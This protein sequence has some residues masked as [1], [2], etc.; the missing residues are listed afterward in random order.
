MDSFEFN[1]IAASVLIALLVAM[2]GK[3]ASDFIIHSTPLEKNSFVIDVPTGSD[4]KAEPKKEE[5]TLTP[6]TPLLA[7][8]DVE[9]GKGVAKKCT[10]CHTFEKGGPN[11]TGPNL[12]NIV[13][14]KI[15]HAADFAYSSGVK[16]LEG[17]TWDFEELN[18]FLKNPRKFI[19]GTKMSF[20]G[21]Q[22]DQ[23]RADLI[24]YLRTLSDNPHPLPT[25]KS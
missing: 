1:K 20:V 17:K 14:A 13:A 9:K 16:A 21:I 7:S 11:R 18:A 5:E 8:A 4:G 24:A 22:N 12:W 3:L 23:E 6:I 10:Q 2:T 25:Q 15:G 19:P